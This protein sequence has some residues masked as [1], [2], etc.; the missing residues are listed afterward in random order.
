M[1]KNYGPIPE[2]LFTEPKK[3]GFVIYPEEDA[4]LFPYYYEGNQLAYAGVKPIYPSCASTITEFSSFKKDIWN[5][6][7]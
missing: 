5:S 3:I 7:V 6:V 4:N 1:E 2:K